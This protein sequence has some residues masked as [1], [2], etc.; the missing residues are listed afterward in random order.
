MVDSSEKNIKIKTVKLL[1]IVKLGHVLMIM[2]FV[3][4]GNKLILRRLHPLI[5]VF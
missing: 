5:H 3:V 1:P 2:K 4:V